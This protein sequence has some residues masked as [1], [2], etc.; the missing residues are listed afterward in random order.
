MAFF[1]VDGVQ[2]YYEVW[3]AS[4]PPVLFLHGLG[5]SSADWGLQVS[6]FAAR[7]PVILADLRGHGRSSA[8][9]R[10]I[11]V[12]AMAEDV[13]RLLGHLGREAV[14]VVSLSLG[15]CVAL[16]LALRAPERVRSLT[17]VNAF[18]RLAPAGISGLIGMGIR[19]GLVMAAPMPVVASHVARRLFP[20]PE[21]Q[22]LYQ[23]AVAS[24]S[25]TPRAVY[26][27]AMRALAGF[28]VRKRLDGVRCPTLIV[29]GDRDT[30]VP[31]AAKEMLQRSIRG[32]R[33]LVVPDSG[34]ATNCDQPDTFNR[35]VLEFLAAN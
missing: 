21:Q 15:G 14:H 35:S 5:S 12:E 16:A 19:L 13:E 23:A 8:A 4:G 6:A 32:A 24:L 29:A 2:L 11:T 20:K 22:G 7:H 18:A 33:L 28:D 9:R 1:S 31:L 10:R 27:S 3:P 26:L 25:R 34:H 17:L 30:T